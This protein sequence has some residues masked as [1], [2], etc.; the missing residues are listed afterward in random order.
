MPHS[1]F[2]P[3]QEDNKAKAERREAEAAAAAAAAAAAQAMLAQL[4]ASKSIYVK[5]LALP[6]LGSIVVTRRSPLPQC[7]LPTLDMLTGYYVIAAASA[8]YI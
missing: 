5:A 4:C 8:V 2:A 1:P 6:S 7:H 3:R